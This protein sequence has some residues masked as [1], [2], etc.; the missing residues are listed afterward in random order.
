MYW[1]IARLVRRS[2]KQVSAANFTIDGGTNGVWRDGRPMEG[3][4]DDGGTDGRTGIGARNTCMSKKAFH[5]YRNYCTDILTR[6]MEWRSN[7]NNVGLWYISSLNWK[8]AELTSAEAAISKPRLRAAAKSWTRR[9]LA[10]RPAPWE[11]KQ[12]SPWLFQGFPARVNLRLLLSAPEV[13]RTDT[14]GR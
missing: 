10:W 9:P 8:Y 11:L 14:P 12:P 5:I 7:G 13:L 4:T 6:K 2:H 3:R 1:I